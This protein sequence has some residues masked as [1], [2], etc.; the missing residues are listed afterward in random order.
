MKLF[1]QRKG[2]I[3]SFIS[4]MI[5]MFLVVWFNLPIEIRYYNKIRLGNQFV[6]N[7]QQYH[8]HYGKLP[9][10]DDWNTLP[11]LNPFHPYEAFYPEYRKIDE[12][13]FTLTFVEGFDPP[14]VRFTTKTGKWSRW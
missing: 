11:K 1:I 4:L 8:T 7:I 2:K 3:L 14:Y 10:E 6:E 9:D 5:G 13:H 12:Q